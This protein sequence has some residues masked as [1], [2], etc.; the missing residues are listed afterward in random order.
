M[1]GIYRGV[2][3][4]F[5]LTQILIELSSRLSAI[6]GPCPQSFFQSEHVMMSLVLAWEVVVAKAANQKRSSPQ[7]PFHGKVVGGS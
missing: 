4:E 7:Q 2:G 1:L 3:G 6:S 5:W